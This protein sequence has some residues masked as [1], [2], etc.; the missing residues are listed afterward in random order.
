MIDKKHKQNSLRCCYDSNLKCL[1]LFINDCK[2]SG[3]G[4]ISTF[5]ICLT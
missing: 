1:L 2:G 5:F 3:V 4:K